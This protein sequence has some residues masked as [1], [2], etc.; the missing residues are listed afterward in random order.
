MHQTKVRLRDF[1]ITDD[2]WIFAVSGYDSTDGV[3]AVLRY[4]PDDGGDRELDGV[5]YRK[6]DFDESSRF[7]A[8]NR[9]SWKRFC[10]P[11][12]EISKVLRAD[13][14]I[15]SLVKEDH[16][17]AAIVDLLERAGIPIEKMGITGS[18][19]PGLQIEGSDIDFVVYGKYWFRARN[20]IVQEMQE[21]R[22]VQIADR[23]PARSQPR[24][25]EISDA[26]W[27]HIYAKRVPEISFE[28]F[29][30]HELRKGNRG[31]VEGTYFDLLFVRDWDQLPVRQ[32]RGDD[33][34]RCS[35]TA[36]VTSAD[37][38][39]DNPAVYEIDHPVISEIFCYTHTYAGQALAGEMVEARGM[40]EQIGDRRRL[41]VGTSR[42]P[43]GEWMRSLELL[44]RG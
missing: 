20:A 9:P 5:R 43:V 17:V 14:R 37:L 29:M 24:I 3:Q 18:M 40:M 42:E 32:E 44:E 21:A 25:T 8:E 13:E 15:Q 12:N 4:I 26:M 2:D 41:V 33:L 34:Y 39:F 22:K 11:E 31:M 36:R 1:F 6:L 10:V 30:I 7:V 27:H 38:A 16:R 23:N 19:L 28:E 35:I